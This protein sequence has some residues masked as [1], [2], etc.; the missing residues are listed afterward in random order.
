L[1]DRE[2]PSAAISLPART[3]GLSRRQFL[4][5]NSALLLASTLPGCSGRDMPPDDRRLFR[6]LRGDDMLSLAFELR[7]LRIEHRYRSSARLL[8]MDAAR[9]AFLVVHF[10]AQHVAEYAVASGT[11]APVEGP[12]PAALAGPSRL[13]FRVPDDLGELVLSPDSLL[14]WDRLELQVAVPD[15][16]TAP[17]PADSR[18]RIEL[19]FGLGLDPDP[20]ARWRH[21]TR[22]VTHNGRTEVWHT[23]LLTRE[24]QTLTVREAGGPFTPRF[25]LTPDAQL[26]AALPGRQ[27]EA[28]RLI[29]SPVGGWLDLRGR[30]E[31]DATLARWDHRASAGRDQHVLTVGALGHLYPF[32][33]AVRLLTVTER[34]VGT[35]RAPGGDTRRAAMLRR[36]VFLLVEEKTRRY[37]PEGMAFRSLTIDIAATP[38]LRQHTPD[39]TPDGWRSPHWVETGDGNAFRFP[40]TGIDWD[41]APS[42]FDATAVFLPAGGDADE[43]ARIYAESTYAARRNCDLRGQSA[44]VALYRGPQGSLKPDYEDER[45]P[46]DTTLKLHRLR[47]TAKRSEDG[48][49]IVCITDA[50]Q[51][52]LPSLEPYLDE[53]RNRGW[54][55]LR[56]PDAPDNKGEVFALAIDDDAARIPMYFDE[57]ADRAG[58]LAAPSFRVGGVSRLH[59]PV[60][61]GEGVLRGDAFDVSKAFDDKRSSFFGNFPLGRLLGIGPDED[62]SPAIPRI[63]FKHKKL[64]EKSKSGTAKEQDKDKDKDTPG[65]EKA[66]KEDGSK[67]AKESA[68]RAITAGLKWNIP[69]EDYGDAEALMRFRASRDGTDETRA[70]LLL[71]VSATRIFGRKRDANGQNPGDDDHGNT[72]KERNLSFAAEGKIS[73]FAL[74]MNLAGETGLV[75]AF[76]YIQVKLGPPK[77][78]SGDKDKNKGGD[79]DT[80]AKDK[81]EPPISGELNVRLAKIDAS[82]ALRFAVRILEKASH[83]PPI[84]E[85]P[86]QEQTADFPARLRAPAPADLPVPIGPFVIPSFEWLNF[87]VRNL[88]LGGSIGLNFLPRPGS[89]GGAPRV[90]DHVFSFRLASADKPMLLVAE[91]WGGLAHLGVNFTPH[92]LTDFQFGLGIVY[93]ATFDLGVTKAHCEGSL[94]GMFTYWLEGSAI[95]TQ[96]DF[97]LTLSGQARLWFLDI[98][99]L[100]VAVGSYQ[101]GEE[102]WAFTATFTVRVRVAFFCVTASFGFYYEVAGEKRNRPDLLADGG[103][104]PDSA[105][106]GLTRDEWARY[107]NAFA[108]MA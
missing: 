10:A 97:V 101:S 78:K 93:S 12:F 60:G 86:G 50:V 105:D 53:A 25:P 2:S 23:R 42:T 76:E 67:S 107:R 40:M 49:G 9:D 92:A 52:G 85:I 4:A 30:W 16:N 47:F 73:D 91:P 36:S 20:S 66:G 88:R 11:Q 28:R 17:K 58:G 46:G 39:A 48:T 106:A 98:Y 103:A 29:L 7:N 69:L 89:D 102:L 87:S 90:P 14:A 84:P 1:P 71:D 68:G 64:E 70:K 33:H 74:I 62:V 95:H 22:P 41:G 24:V 83:L 104:A 108:G 51:A 31:G 82:G 13:V 57:Q 100:L 15:D 72:T 61:D 99:L 94:A 55:E 65:Q 19:P 77:E 38:A 34:D 35:V 27:V 59:G 81:K 44:V 54:F 56:D 18:S 32:G 63:Y 96:T 3:D 21:A 80:E 37:A 6:W 26:R 5:L 8:R 79:T 45:T 75:F 43:A